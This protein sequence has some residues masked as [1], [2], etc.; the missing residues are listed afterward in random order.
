MVRGS[1]ASLSNLAYSI[2]LSASSSGLT[3]ELE[4]LAASFSLLGVEP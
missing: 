4:A 1:P 2:E 3:D